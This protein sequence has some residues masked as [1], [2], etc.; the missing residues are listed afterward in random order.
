MGII[1]G[2][3]KARENIL[4]E[5]FSSLLKHLVSKYSTLVCV[6]NV[7]Y[8]MYLLYSEEKIKKINLTY[9]ILWH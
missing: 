1:G 6:V 2:R 3:I 4:M 7:A 5:K 9:S 8:C